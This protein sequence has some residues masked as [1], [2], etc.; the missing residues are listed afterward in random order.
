MGWEEYMGHMYLQQPYGK[1]LEIFY[2]VEEV[3]VKKKSKYQDIMVVRLAVF[4]KSLV[5]DGLIQSTEADEH[6]Y[7]EAL[8]QPAMHLHPC[9]ERVLILGGGEGATLREALKHSCVREAV[10]VDID[11]VVI[12]VAKEYLPEWHRG[13]FDDPRAKVVVEDAAKYVA[14]A[15]ERRE[16]F[17]V[18]VMDLT[19]PYGPEIAQHIYSREFLEKIKAILSEKG[20]VVTQAGNSF[21]YTKPYDSLVN[22]FKQVFSEA[23]EY[24]AWIPSFMYMNNY[25]L[26]S[27]DPQGLEK[28]LTRIDER[29]RERNVPLRFYNSKTH[30][31]MFEY[32]IL[33]RG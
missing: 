9:P 33:R 15:L 4:G 28:E 12:E 8:V 5:L 11:D 2:R 18:V 22:V 13:A 19:D 32:P 29:I 25:V 21:F 14:E 7:H 3:I 1:D 20:I 6:I 23:H 10:M 17:D 16:L 31:A 30:R 26:A 24:S 27:K